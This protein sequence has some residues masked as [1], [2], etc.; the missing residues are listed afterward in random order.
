MRPDSPSSSSES[1]RTSP[2]T[3]PSSPP[4]ERT[5]TYYLLV[6]EASAAFLEALSVAKGGD[7]D[8]VLLCRGSGHVKGLLV[9]AAD[10]LQDKIVLDET[11]WVRVLARDRGSEVAYFRT[12]PDVPSVDEKSSVDFGAIQF[13]TYYVSCRIVAQSLRV[14]T[15]WR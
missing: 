3:A 1:S 2:S 10:V 13:N 7:D 14:L 6:H 9:Q 15:R 5:S 8:R 12:Q 4:P 11:A